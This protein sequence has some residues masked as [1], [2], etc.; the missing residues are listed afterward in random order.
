MLQ[1]GSSKTN[2]HNASLASVL[3]THDPSTL[4][5]GGY[6]PVVDPMLSPTH[7]RSYS[8][9]SYAEN[10]DGEVASAISRDPSIEPDWSG[11]AASAAHV[12]LLPSNSF[13]GPVPGGM[14]N[15]NI[16]AIMDSRKGKG[17]KR[18]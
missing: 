13:T 4:A 10:Y 12:P 2:L 7:S 16:D 1:D 18:R 14:N 15:L 11:A 17:K 3:S 6:H 5:P 8:M 9:N